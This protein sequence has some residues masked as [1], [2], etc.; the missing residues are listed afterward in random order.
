MRVFVH[1][2]YYGPSCDQTC[3][4]FDESEGQ[5]ERY[6]IECSDNGICKQNGT[7]LRCQCYSY[8]TGDDCSN[9]CPGSYFDDVVK[10]VVECS[11]QGKCSLDGTE[12]QCECLPGYHGEDCNAECP[13]T[14]F[15]DDGT[16]IE[17]SGHGTCVP[18]PDSSPGMESFVCQCTDGYSG[19]ACEGSCPGIVE[20]DGVQ[21]GCN[22]HGA[23]EDNKCVCYK[24]YYG[25]ECDKSCPGL[26][27]GE[28]GSLKECNGHGTCDSDTLTCTCSDSRYHGDDCTLCCL[29]S[30]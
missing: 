1:H 12:A 4:G 7:D 29:P 8:A 30:S 2:S 13:G 5:G 24:G 26:L 16:A 15:N 10:E 6:V 18:S 23:C 17:C 27:Q 3:P 20:V 25:E 9:A 22:G 28:D 21:M 14:E 19:E 11:N